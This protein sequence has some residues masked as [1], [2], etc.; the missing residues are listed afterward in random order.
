MND[1]DDTF[2]VK[3]CGLSTPETLAVAL[4]AGADM[5]G[6]NF[7]P[8]S[9]RFV[10]IAQATALAAMARG[11]AEIVALIVDWD[12]TQAMSLVEAVKPDW[13]QLHGRETPEQV[14]ALKAATGLPVMKALG[15]AGTEDLAA[16]EAHRGVAD[17]ILLDAKPP[18]G[19]AY[20]GGHGRPFDWT[21]LAELDP[22]L[23]FMLS[24]GLDPANIA[25]AIRITR[26]AGVDVSSGVETA[27]GV[28]DA[29]RIRDFIA[30]A[31]AGAQSLRP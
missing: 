2:A 22:G 17:R 19:A 6:L 29:G 7:H 11:R 5:I 13:L 3:I 1:H 21:L 8:R 12:E 24:G 30:A 28:K 10:T 26:P 20:P 4:D 15:I 23:R 14:R 27:P 9:P 31:R 18:K 25:E 16:V